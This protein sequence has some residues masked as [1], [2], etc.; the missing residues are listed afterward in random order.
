MGDFFSGFFAIPT[1]SAILNIKYNLNLSVLS[2][3]LNISIYYFIIIGILI[4]GRLE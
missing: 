2:C 3:C 4:V 1:L